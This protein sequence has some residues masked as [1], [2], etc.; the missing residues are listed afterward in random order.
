MCTCFKIAKKNQ[1]LNLV[2]QILLWIVDLFPCCL[3]CQKYLRNWCV[4]DKTLNE[5]QII[6]YGQI[7]LASA[8]IQILQMQI[9][10]LDYVYSSLDSK[11]STIAVYLDF[12]KHMTQLIITYWWVSFCIMASERSCSA[13]LSRI[14][15]TG[16]KTSQSETAIPLCQPLH[17]V[18][19]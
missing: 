3:S 18:L 1:F 4:P 9:E 12:S 17:W 19:H 15:L 16:N 6:F 5:N 13:G 10:F 11:Q 2:N 7:S 14:W 8:K